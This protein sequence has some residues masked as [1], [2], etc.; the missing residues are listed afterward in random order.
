MSS[1]WDINLIYDIGK[2]IGA[3]FVNG[4]QSQ[5]VGA[6]VKHYAANNQEYHRQNINNI[7]E[8][9]ALNEIYLANFER[10]V[11]KASP[12]VVMAAYNKLN[13]VHCTENKY[14]LTDILRNQWNFQGFVVSDWYSVD[15][16]VNSLNAGLDLEMPYSYGINRKKIIE[17]VLNGTLDES[18]LN[19]AVENILNIVFRVAKNQKAYATYN[20][21]KHNDLAREAARNCIVLLKNK[22]NLL[23]LKKEML[24]NKKIAIIGEYAIKPRYQGGGSAHITPTMIGNGYDEIVKLSGKSIKIY[25]SK[26]N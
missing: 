7:I 13:G 18:V 20:K 6:C 15:S 3:A 19:M 21:E 10:V 17:A 8:E 2:A 24:K 16:I 11:K 22:H 26:K 1:S 14:L 9:Q 25:Y 23:P 5:S 4:V 12:W